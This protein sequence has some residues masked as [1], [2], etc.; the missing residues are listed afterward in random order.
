MQALAIYG[1]PVPP[2]AVDYLLQPYVP[3]ID[4]A[5]VLGRLVNMQFVRRDAGRYYLHQ[6]D[7]DYALEPHPEGSPP[8][9]TPAPPFTRYALLPPRR[10]VLRRAPAR[11]RET[12]RRW[13][14]WPPSWPS[15]SCARRR[16]LRHR[17]RCC[18]R[19]T[20]TTCCCG[21]MPATAELHERLQATSPTVS[22]LN[23]LSN[24][25]I[26]F[27]YLGHYRRAIGY[28]EQALAM[29]ARSGTA[30]ARAL[31]SATS[32]SATTA[33]G[34]SAAPST[35][36][37]RTWPSPARSATARRGQ[38]LGNLGLCYD[39][40]GEFGR[41]IDHHEAGTWPSPARSATARARARHSATWASAT[42][43]L[44][45]TAAPSSIMSRRLAIAR[46]IGDRRGEGSD[47]GNLGNCYFSLGEYGRASSS[48]SRPWPSLGRS[49]TA[50]ASAYAL[51]KSRR[52]V[53][54]YR[55]VWCRRVKYTLQDAQQNRRCNTAQPTEPARGALWP[56]PRPP[57]R[58]R[59]GSGA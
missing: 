3:G 18:S 23:N 1:R 26:A 52:C 27:Y 57:V 16:G 29:P 40:L 56:R 38:C 47:L 39:N 2:V 13:T 31:A 53:H 17:G 6:V 21:A 42:I 19:S 9:G 28:H 7:R 11:P 48:P 22:Y 4:S 55:S 54:E 50:P 43:H 37:S 49:A 24:L 8:T 10:G 14:T 58:G 32:A 46:E 45:T 30:R 15:S 5:P 35:I 33:W 34:T 25:G 20:S 36:T 59:L 41:A 51:H 12:G 44:G